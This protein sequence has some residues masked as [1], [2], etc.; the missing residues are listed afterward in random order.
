ML[1]MAAKLDLHFRLCCMSVCSL[2]M[3]HMFVA[4]SPVTPLARGCD[5]EGVCSQSLFL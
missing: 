1:Q 5:G 2:G 4:D 3:Q